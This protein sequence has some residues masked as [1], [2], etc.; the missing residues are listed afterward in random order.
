MSEHHQTRPSQS[1]HP[2]RPPA[3]KSVSLLHSPGKRKHGDDNPEYHLSRTSSSVP[4]S[5][6][7]NPPSPGS[8]KPCTKKESSGEVSDAGKWFETSN[9]NISQ[10]SASFVD[11]DPPFFFRNS[12]SSTS[13]DMQNPLQMQI[14]AQT[15][16]PHRPAL[17]NLRTDGSS[18]EDFRSV[19]DDLTIENKKLKKKLKKYEKI[20]DAHLQDEKLFEVR[21]HRLP[22]HKKREL[23]ET[24]RKFAMELDDGSGNEPVAT[25]D[26]PSLHPQRTLSSYTSTQFGDSAYH[27]MS[28]SGQNSNAASGG[29]GNGNGNGQSY[30]KSDQ[31]NTTSNHRRQQDSIQSYLQ[32]IPRG[33]MPKTI[34]MTETAKKKLVVRRMEQLFAGKGAGAQHQQPMQQ[35]EVAQSAAQADRAAKEEITGHKAEREGLRE[36]RIMDDKN[37]HRM[38]APRDAVESDRNVK[39]T[40][41]RVS[42]RD[43]ADSPSGSNSPNQRP[44]R[45]LDLDPQR[46]QVPTENL[47]YIRH[48]GFSP[49]DPDTPPVDGHGWIYLNLLVNMAQ[50]HTIN[51]TIDFVKKALQE[52]SSKLE[53]SHDGRKVRWRGGQDTS[54]NSSDSSP[55]HELEQLKSNMKALG[56]KRQKLGPSSTNTSSEATGQSSEQQRSNPLAYTPLFYHKASTDEFDSEAP[57]SEEE[58]SPFPA[59]ATGNTS[60]GFASS[61]MRTSS[62]K[63]KRDDGPIIFYNK[64]RFCTDLSGDPNAQTPRGHANYDHYTDTPLGATPEKERKNALLADDERRGPLTRAALQDMDVD[65]EPLSASDVELEFPG[66][67]SSLEEG[68]VSSNANFDFEVSGI[69]GVVPED[70]FSIDVECRNIR[71]DS[72]PAHKYASHAPRAINY[73]SKIMNALQVRDDEDQMDEGQVKRY[74][75]PIYNGEYIKAQQ[76]RLPPSILPPPSL[77][78]FDSS[79]GGADTDMSDVSEMD[80]EF[81]ESDEPPKAAPRL[82]EMDSPEDSNSGEESEEGDSEEEDSEEE[83]SEDGSVDFLAQA[84]ELDPDAIRAYEREYDANMAERLA[85]EIPAGS[86]AATAGGGSGFNSPNSTK[87]DDDEPAMDRRPSS[88]GSY[89]LHRA[90]SMKRSRT[91]DSMIVNGEPSRN[92]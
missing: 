26:R 34:A 79:S 59:Q 55:E 58:A 54:L 43:F 60:S 90:A 25:F 14:Q 21:V 44:T 80:D 32:D 81:E 65:M 35:Q 17:M 62:S 70:N 9:N 73:P 4:S 23:E 50:L 39:K 77:L 76:R 10:H 33:L 42:D 82:V 85:E 16:I 37:E 61:G 92:E 2:R 56:R 22:A 66:N 5:E 63:R 8:S 91:S 15:S 83:E 69:G 46:A 24:L 72:G 3:H 30:D 20:H 19:I 1:A 28:A 11:N 78:P 88:Q 75:T 52:Y 41:D 7:A 57:N 86:S 36:A 12:S 89:T 87:L 48:L 47:K 31:K 67:L 84:R 27:S 74:R 6:R 38:A 64:A 13:P 68:M 45:P 18:T 53:I 71:S 40:G 29:N 49:P 51:V